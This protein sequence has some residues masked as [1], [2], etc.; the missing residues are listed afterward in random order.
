MDDTTEI[1]FKRLEETQNEFWNVARE[2]GNFLNMLVKICNAQNAYEIGT[3]NGYS[4][5]WL[6]KALKETGGHLTTIEFYEKRR[7]L[8]EENF[9]TCGVMDVITTKEGSAIGILERLPEDEIIDFVFVDANKSQYIE[10]FNLLDKHLKKGAVICA[11]NVT[12]HAEKVKPFLD[13]VNGNPKYQ[14][15][16]LDLPAGL[17]V[18]RK[19]ED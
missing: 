14:M 10:Y 8:A 13:A 18:A 11:D 4:G 9:K 19:N 17:A 1:V 6:A 16:V 15:E 2:T 7:V 12:S 3:S 5:I